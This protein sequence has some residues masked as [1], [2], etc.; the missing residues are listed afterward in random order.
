VNT[1]SNEECYRLFRQ[2]GMLDNIVDHSRQVCRVATFLTDQLRKTDLILNRKLVAAGALLHDITKTRSFDTGEDH[3]KTGEKFVAGL[4]YREVG[5]IVGQHVALN[6]YFS[7]NTPDEAEIVNYA[8]KRVLHDQI[9]SMD[10]RMEYILERYCQKPGYSSRLERLWKASRK[11]E[12]RIFRYL[13][14]LPEELKQQMTTAT[15]SS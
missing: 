4:G 7:T 12:K 9:V 15:D 8:D 11:M 6:S 1:P 10:K 14:F 5:K 3:A 2:T 13:S